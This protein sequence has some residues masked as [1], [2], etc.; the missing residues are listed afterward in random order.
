MIDPET[1]LAI[2]L[3]NEVVPV[4]EAVTAARAMA[5]RSVIPDVVC[6]SYP[7]VESRLCPGAT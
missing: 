4:G 7:P 1:A 3:V 2:G 6:E 5:A